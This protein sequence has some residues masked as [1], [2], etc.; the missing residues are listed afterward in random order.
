M[1][2]QRSQLNKEVSTAVGSHLVMWVRIGW[3]SSTS[4]GRIFYTMGKIFYSKMF[5]NKG[6]Q[7]S[8]SHEDELPWC[9][10]SRCGCR[11][12]P[13]SKHQVLAAGQPQLQVSC[14]SKP[15]SS[16]SQII[17]CFLYNSSEASQRS[18]ALPFCSLN[19]SAMLS[20]DFLFHS[21]SYICCYESSYRTSEG[22]LGDIFILPY[23]YG[24]YRF[25]W[26]W[27]CCGTL[28]L[29]KLFWKSL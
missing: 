4:V 11:W 23:L 22:S 21:V 2:R 7:T 3:P 8:A 26:L 18:G 1:E 29:A 13:A 5:W 9:S 14:F 17:P 15:L 19:I 24:S 25:A 28:S 12:V 27:S 16:Q 20:Q 6:E 10:Y